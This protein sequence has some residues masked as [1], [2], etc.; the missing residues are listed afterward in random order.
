[1]NK[2]HSS[3]GIVPDSLYR[4]FARSRVVIDRLGLHQQYGALSFLE[5]DPSLQGGLQCVV[6]STPP[7]RRDVV[8][9]DSPSQSPGPFLTQEPRPSCASMIPELF[10]TPPQEQLRPSLEEPPQ[11]SYDGQP[12][13]ELLCKMERHN[14]EE[15]KRLVVHYGCSVSDEWDIRYHFHR[16][17]TDQK[18]TISGMTRNARSWGFSR[19]SK[20]L[21]NS[22]FLCQEPPFVQR[23]H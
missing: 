4:L 18:Q 19:L 20:F 1:M 23:R 13:I 11:P 12:S 8:F 7:R 6:C 9:L 15:F 17:L 10:P 14:P 2:V 21:I 5:S 16:H 3:I 22:Q